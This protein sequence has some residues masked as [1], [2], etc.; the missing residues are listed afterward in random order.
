MTSLRFE[1]LQEF[2]AS[3][4]ASHQVFGTATFSPRYF[5][6]LFS[7]NLETSLFRFV[8]I[9]RNRLN[10][11]RK[12]HERVIQLFEIREPQTNMRVVG[13]GWQLPAHFHPEI[14]NSDVKKAE[15]HWTLDFFHSSPYGCS[16]P[17]PSSAPLWQYELLFLLHGRSSLHSVQVWQFEKLKMYE[18][19]KRSIKSQPQKTMPHYRS[20][21]K[22]STANMTTHRTIS[23]RRNETKNT[24]KYEMLCANVRHGWCCLIPSHSA[25]LMTCLSTTSVSVPMLDLRRVF[26]LFWGFVVSLFVFDVLTFVFVFVFSC[27]FCCSKFENIAFPSSTPR[28][29]RCCS[30][31]A[32]SSLASVILW[33]WLTSRIWSLRIWKFKWKKWKSFKV[34][35]IGDK[36]RRQRMIV[37]I[38][39]HFHWVPLKRIM[40]K[41]NKKN[42]HHHTSHMSSK[43]GGK[44]RKTTR[45]RKRF[46]KHLP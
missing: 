42:P 31:A 20:R 28:C 8:F 35:V 25:F 1:N 23:T 26:M 14:K 13:L 45:R 37:M 44:K 33:T 32:S 46:Q 30:A 2:P 18:M 12:L 15:S 36:V 22:R 7:F 17:T 24:T 16:T 21:C 11:S 43:K 9:L 3:V 10:R 41:W 29:S 4:K 34:R 40:I 19:M 39:D 5:Q 27:R 38:S 6:I